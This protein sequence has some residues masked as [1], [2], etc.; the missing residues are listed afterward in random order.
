MNMKKL[1]LP[2]LAVSLVIT[3]FFT[4]VVA[5]VTVIKHPYATAYTILTSSFGFDIDD[6]LF[7]S[8][9]NMTG[10]K[11]VQMLFAND[12]DIKKQ[13]NQM[14]ENTMIINKAGLIVIFYDLNDYTSDELSAIVQIFENEPINSK[15]LEKIK[16][17]TFI[18]NKKNKPLDETVL[19]ALK[20]ANTMIV[21]KSSSI[22]GLTIRQ[23][24]PEY[25]PTNPFYFSD[26]N[27]F[28]AVGL[29]GQCTWYSYGRI[30]EMAAEIDYD[31]DFNAL[32][33]LRGNGADWYE[34]A[35][36]NQSTFLISEDI[37]QPAAG[38]IISWGGGWYSGMECG[39]VGIVESVNEDGT[40]NISESSYYG[41]IIFR[42]TENLT[43]NDIMYRAS[44]NPAHPL[45]FQCYIYCIENQDSNSEVKPIASLYNNL[46]FQ[47]T[48]ANI[49]TSS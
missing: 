23:E 27:I 7:D 37:S 41:S 28:H 5:A 24:S 18:Q 44:G 26:L 15:A 9:D 12:P 46:T 6:D 45:Y 2:I 30:M 42:Y 11:I 10:Y 31:L 25:D 47:K 16:Q 32:R 43:V 34:Q 14:T 20:T 33:Q 35:K 8:A 1:L 38:S 13:L 29:D 48:Y 40:I 17:L 19:E 4:P 39:H 49:W 36:Y 3:L 22:A 21:G